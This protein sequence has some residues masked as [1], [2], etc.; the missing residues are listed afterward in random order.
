MGWG[1]LVWR[2]NPRKGVMGVVI[3]VHSVEVQWGW[4]RGSFAFFSCCRSHGWIMNEGSRE[5]SKRPWHV[6]IYPLQMVCRWV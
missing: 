4:F 3:P 2:I 6:H 5:G 1:G